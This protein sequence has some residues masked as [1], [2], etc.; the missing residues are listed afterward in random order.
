MTLIIAV[1]SIVISNRRD[2]HSAWVKD[3]AN[4]YTMQEKYETI[5]GW[6]ILVA[7]SLFLSLLAPLMFISELTYI[8]EPGVWSFFTD[9][10]SEGYHSMFSYLIYF[11]VFANLTLFVFS[12]ILV[13]LFFKKKS[14]FPQY[15][16]VFIIVGLFA[17]ITDAILANLIFSS[18]PADWGLNIPIDVHISSIG[19]VLLYAAVWIP[20]MVKSIRVKKTFVH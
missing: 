20:Y 7:F 8:F 11:E 13:I 15:L 19:G 2:V 12:I 10:A 9:P 18:Y 5:G 14:V 3:K 17:L 16:I 4:P 1:V 6:L